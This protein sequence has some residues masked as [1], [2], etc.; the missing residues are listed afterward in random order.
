MTAGTDPPG[1]RPLNP[2]PCARLH[3][4]PSSSLRAGTFPQ[5]WTREWRPSDLPSLSHPWSNPDL[6][7]GPHSPCGWAPGGDREPRQV[8][9][10]ERIQRPCQLRAVAPAGVWGSFPG[11]VVPEAPRQRTCSCSNKGP[12]TGGLQAQR[13]F[14]LTPGSRSS[15]SRCLQ[16][17]LLWRLGRQQGVCPGPFPGFWWICRPWHSLTWRHAAPGLRLHGHKTVFPVHVCPRLSSVRTPP[18]LYTRMISSLEPN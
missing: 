16:G 1:P 14:S 13:I 12:R 9:L 2:R 17:R 10:E 3:V 4:G 11:P 5:D 6:T 8:H 15:G 18:A 7:L